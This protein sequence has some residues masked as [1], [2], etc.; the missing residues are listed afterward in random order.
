MSVQL[1][2]SMSEECRGSKDVHLPFL[3]HYALYAAKS[4]H[5]AAA[6]L[7]CLQD[8]LPSLRIRKLIPSSSHVEVDEAGYSMHGKSP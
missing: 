2:S 8:L 7:T 4:S 6:T 3:I 1:G 5:Q